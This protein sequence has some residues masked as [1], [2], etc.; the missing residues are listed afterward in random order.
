MANEKF[1]Q[2][3]PLAEYCSKLFQAVGMPIEEADL[4]ADSLV[5]A[6]LTGVESHGVSR[7]PIYLKRIREKVV[8]PKCEIRLLRG[9]QAAGVFDAC[10]SM[11]VS[12]A[13]RVMQH[14]LDKA[15]QQGIAFFSAIN[16][17]HF[18]TA[19]YFAKMA[20][21]RDMI[22]FST[23][24][25]PARMAPWGGV[26]PYFGTNPFAVAIP[27]AE[28]LPIVMD[29]ATSVVA[30]GKIVLAARKNEAIPEGWALN[31]NGEST[32]DAKQ[33]LVGSVLPF[34]GAKGSA[35]ALMIDT[36]C[37]ILG[38]SRFGPGINDMYADF[39]HPTFTS[40]VFAAIK[41][42]AFTPVESFKA[43]TDR[44]IR[45]IKQNRPASGVK[46]VYLPGE[47]EWRKR[48]ERLQNG[49]PVPAVILD[50]LKKEGALCDVACDL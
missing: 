34:A 25:S 50:D 31:N 47:I 13:Y 2:S 40:H 12:A 33:A 18:G 30:R 20:L 1:I 49:I 27:A 4:N 22:G 35:I 26:E 24:N 39:T 9:A 8:N 14:V 42:S 46:E 48:A 15:D 38:G 44:M 32:T 6:D 17:N 41:I 28:E 10:N 19:A 29:M 7:M 43:D 5:E 23:T 37:G 16:S 45:E 3:K 11:G 36:I 21:G